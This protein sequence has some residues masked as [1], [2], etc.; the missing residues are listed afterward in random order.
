MLYGGGGRRILQGCLV[1]PPLLRPSFCEIRDLASAVRRSRAAKTGLAMSVAG[2]AREHAVPLF[3]SG[4]KRVF[5]SYET[6][7]LVSTWKFLLFFNGGFNAEKS[8]P[9]RHYETLPGLK[10]RR[11]E[12]EG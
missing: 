8:V 7:G 2:T 10:R 4:L 9:G 1:P 11:E 6:F 3:L 12:G 5:V